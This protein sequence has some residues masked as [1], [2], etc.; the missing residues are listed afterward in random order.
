MPQRS[1]DSPPRRRSTGEKV[2]SPWRALGSRNGVDRGHHRPGEPPPRNR[3]ATPRLM[4]P[5]GARLRHAGGLHAVSSQIL[6]A[7]GH[8]PCSPGRVLPGMRHTPPSCIT[9]KAAD[10][11]TRHGCLASS[12]YSASSGECSGPWSNLMRLTAVR[13]RPRE[14][15]LRRIVQGAGAM[16]S[17]GRSGG[18]VSERHTGIPAVSDLSCCVRG[19]RDTT[20]PSPDDDHGPGQGVTRSREIAAFFGDAS[21]LSARPASFDFDYCTGPETCRPKPSH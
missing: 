18:S 1:L 8:R 7:L 6:P 3:L 15:I 2:P 14:R 19:L 21:R 5:A 13:P 10:G 4:W 11:R 16:S 17:G 20:I 12:L 9:G